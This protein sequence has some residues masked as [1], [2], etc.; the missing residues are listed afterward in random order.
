MKILTIDIGTGTQDIFLYDSQL[1]IENGFKL[2]VPSPTMI[3]H[4]Q[5]KAATKAER[6]ILINGVIMGGGPSAWAVEAHVR[7]GLKTYATPTAAKT[8]NDELEKVQALGIEIVSEDEAAT[9]SLALFYK[10]QGR[11]QDALHLL[12]EF[13]A[14][15]PASLGAAVLL[16][17]LYSNFG[18]AE[19]LESFLNAT[20]NL[21]SSA[22]DYVCDVCDYRDRL[23]RW[24]CPECNSFDSFISAHAE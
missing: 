8:L 7:A 3:I 12:E 17:S 2:V 18:E 6:T 22:R 4:Q 14:D 11:E 9:L 21:G 13:T 15:A 16:A 24:H 10:K 1:Q 5:I 19:T 20:I 23:M